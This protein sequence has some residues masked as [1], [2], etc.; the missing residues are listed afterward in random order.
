[1]SGKGKR[2]GLQLNKLFRTV[3]F[4]GIAGWLCCYEIGHHLARTTP[5]LSSSESKSSQEAAR[6]SQF[7]SA[8]RY[9]P[10]F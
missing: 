1:M 3:Q 10:K 7:A 8:T 2:K 5:F 4:P 9:I 6:Y